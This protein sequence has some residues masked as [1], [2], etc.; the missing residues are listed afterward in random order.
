MTREP[1]GPVGAMASLADPEERRGRVFRGGVGR[2]NTYLGRPAPSTAQVQRLLGMADALLPMQ[3]MTCRPPRS[4]TDEV[5][6]SASEIAEAGLDPRAAHHNGV[7][8]HAQH[9]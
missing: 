7:V 5:L 1:V 6:L 2:A 3:D 4:V 9:W 8:R